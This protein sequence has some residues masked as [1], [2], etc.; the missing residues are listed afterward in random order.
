MMR[1]KVFWRDWLFI[2]LIGNIKWVIDMVLE[3]NKQKNEP[4]VGGVF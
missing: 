4:K 3:N 1:P 2:C